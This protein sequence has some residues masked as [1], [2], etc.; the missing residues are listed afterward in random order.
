VRQGIAPYVNGR[1]YVPAIAAGDYLFLGEHGSLFDGPAHDGAVCAVMQ[2]GADGMILA[3]NEVEET[4]TAPPV[5]E[6]DRIYI[7]TDPSL[8]CVGYTGDDGRAYEADVNARYLLPELE[9]MPPRDTP[10]VEI[11]PTRAVV[12]WPPVEF[13]RFI[14]HSMSFVGPFAIANADAVL[15]ALGGI[16]KVSEGVCKEPQSP[17]A[18]G[19]RFPVEVA[20]EEIKGGYKWPGI[21]A[22]AAKCLQGQT[23][24]AAFFQNA[25]KNDRERVVRV[26]AMHEPP[27]IWICGQPVAEGVRVRLKPGVYSLVALVHNTEAMPAALGFHFRFDDSSDVAAERQAWQESLRRAKPVLERIARH[28]TNA[29][30]AGKARQILAA[31]EDR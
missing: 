17:G 15:T 11:P 10:P 31:L 23:N 26:W 8:I 21:E 25:F 2:K 27:D 18:P 9:V 28:G 19:V 16:A 1:Q 6:G 22:N 14:S 24:K 12:A 7:R 3:Q 13:A 4:W 29:A 5:F 20:G 30:W